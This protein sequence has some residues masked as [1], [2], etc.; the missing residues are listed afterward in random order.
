MKALGLSEEKTRYH[1]RCYKRRQTCSLGVNK[2]VHNFTQQKYTSKV[3]TLCKLPLSTQLH[4]FCT[5][6]G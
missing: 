3:C 1:S 4:F 5:Q 2:W 6:C